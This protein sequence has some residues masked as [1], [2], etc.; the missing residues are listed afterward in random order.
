M[1]NYREQIETERRAIERR[2]A[3][4]PN[5]E[6]RIRYMEALS[7]GISKAAARK[8]ADMETRALLTQKIDLKALADRLGEIVHKSWMEKRKKEKG[9]HN[10]AE[11]PHE[12]K[13]CQLCEG[14][15]LTLQEDGLL[16]CDDC[17]NRQPT[18]VKHKCSDCH[19]C[20]VPY[21]ELSEGE[22]ELDRKYPMEFFNILAKAGYKIVKVM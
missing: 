6:W 11:C 21:S 18:T 22:K 10:P 7:T 2:L 8:V 1:K 15:S 16:K 12:G 17:G 13:A 9:W 4:I 20:M 5:I 19:L 3:E 14:W